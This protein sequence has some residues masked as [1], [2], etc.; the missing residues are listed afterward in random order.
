MIDI[1]KH[2]YFLLQILR[3]VYSEI[4]IASCLGFKGGTALMFFYDLPRFSVDIDFN[5]ICKDKEQEVFG[6]LRQIL[7]KYGKIH[8]EAMKYYGSVIVLD[9]CVRE[10]KLKIEV[11]NREFNDRY[12]IKNFLGINMKVMVREDMFAHKLCAFLDRPA[13]AN[14]DIFDCWFFM[15]N[16]TPV[17]RTIVE[18]RMGVSYV[19][20]L[21]NCI[22]RLEQVNEKTLLQGMG[23]L[24]DGKMKSFV[25]SKLR[26]E[27]IDYM[28]FYREFPV[29]EG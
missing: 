28:K 2:R 22:S 15:K 12:E 29:F 3:D 13:M 24:L 26:S 1:N 18:G 27:L 21:T 8:D 25:K 4:S 17:N 9:Y 20:H 7:L 14:R 5:L 6:S 16:R 19:E 23:Q 11:S 10:R